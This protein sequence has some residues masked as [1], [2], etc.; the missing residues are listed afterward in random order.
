MKVADGLCP[1]NTIVMTPN[2]KGVVQ[3]FKVEGGHLYYMVRH[4]IKEMT[5]TD[6]VCLTPKSLIDPEFP[7]GLWQYNTAEVRRA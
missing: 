5:A 1:V 4:T 2:G 3:G 7:T 6:G